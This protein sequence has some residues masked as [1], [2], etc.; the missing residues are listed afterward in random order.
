MDTMGILAD[1][2]RHWA[3][4]DKRHGRGFRFRRP[5]LA[6]CVHQLGD[7]RSRR[8]LAV[9]GPRHVGKTVLLWQ[10][11][12][13]LLDRGVS[14]R[15]VAYCNLADERWDTPPSPREIITAVESGLPAETSAYF[16]LDEIQAYPKWHAWLKSAVDGGRHRFL[17]TGSAASTLRQGAR[18]SG[19]GRWDE[20]AIEA[21]TF[22]EFA[23][24]RGELRREGARVETAPSTFERYLRSGGFPAHAFE[25]S[26][27]RVRQR[28]REDVADRAIVRDLLRLRVDVEQARRLFLFLVGNSG[29]I[30]NAQQRS[31]DLEVNRK[32]LAKWLEILLDTRLVVALGPTT[33]RQG[34]GPGKAARTLRGS[35][36]LYVADH[37]IINAFAAVP[38]P[39]LDPHFRGQ[40][41]E[42]LVLRH[43][44]EAQ[45]N[46]SDDPAAHS[47]H[48][49]LQLSYWR[50]DRGEIDFVLDTRSERI[51]IE[52]TASAKLDSEKLAKFRSA[53]ER[54]GATRRVFISAGRS[55]ERRGNDL[56]VPIEQFA[57]EPNLVLEGCQ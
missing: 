42:A 3:D 56:M 32:S 45:R 43:L 36:K 15:Q 39:P 34:R 17:V 49:D 29:A 37:G 11:A 41:F 28:L 16:L 51:A 48:G 54:A 26:A 46:L 44:R 30:L 35:S 19:L 7:D 57:A 4:S 5:Q 52:V 13:E 9:I 22:A 23:E 25:E 21:L 10:V 31:K 8:A 55:R 40:M 2:N 50:D 33:T 24:L 18:E 1:H 27:A 38:D 14:A 20:V 6:R 12:D 53:A 47:R